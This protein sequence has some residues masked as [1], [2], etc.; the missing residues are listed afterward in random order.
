MNVRVVV[1]LLVLSVVFPFLTQAKEDPN[2]TG[3]S[4]TKSLQNIAVL[5]ISGNFKDFAREDL[6]A[7]ASRLE[8]E[9]QKTGKMK[10]LER[11]NMDVIFKSK[12]SNRLELAIQ[13]NVRCKSVSF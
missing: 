9:L 11:R 5:E 4:S 10:V 8:T 2:R 1:Q 12:A 7:V 6:G 3:P 13:V